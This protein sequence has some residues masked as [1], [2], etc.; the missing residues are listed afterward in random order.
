MID[1]F[2]QKLL[3]KFIENLSFDGWTKQNIERSCSELAAQ[4]IEH[5]Q[6]T[7]KQNYHKILFPDGLDS[8]T[9]YFVEY[10]NKNFTATINIQQVQQLRFTERVIFLTH[11]RILHYHTVLGGA[12]GFKKFIAYCSTANILNSIANIFKT[13]D[14]IWY[15]TGDTSTDFNYYTKRL[16]LSFIYTSSVVYSISDVSENLSETK[17]FIES[18]VADILKINKLKQSVKNFAEKFNFFIKPKI[19][20]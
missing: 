18:R 10:N 16:S 2:K 17:K 3:E 7:Y 12:E 4:A 8:L 19:K 13:A 1:V 20:V 5:Q 15:I 14:E 11:A 6:E 9:A